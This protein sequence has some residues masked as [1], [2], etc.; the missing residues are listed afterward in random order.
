MGGDLANISVRGTSERLRFKMSNTGKIEMLGNYVVDNGT[1][2]SKAVLERT[3]QISKG[4]N[5]QWDGNPMTPDLN[6]NATYLRTISNA[7]Q[8]LQM[9]NL[10]PI[11]VQLITKISGKLNDPQIE[12][13]IDAPD[14]SSQLKEALATK[15]SNKDERIMQFGSILVLNS[16]NTSNI[17]G[18]ADMKVGAVAGSTGYNILF[19][20]LG[21]VLSAIS[22]EVQ[23]DLDYISGDAASNTGDRA[24][25]NLKFALSPRWTF[26]TG[27]GI[28]ITR[29][30]NANAQYLSGQG[31][32]EYDWS[33]NNDGS[34]LLRMYSKP[35]NIGLLPGVGNTSANQA[36]GAGV[37]YSKSFNSLF[38]SNKKAKNKKSNAMNNKIDSTKNTILK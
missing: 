25:A 7:G 27:L 32:I 18:V 4:S 13:N 2:L 35:S 23:V 38:K 31:I 33:K 21:S 9:N 34:R 20:Q 15:L 36:Y 30:D 10:P 37:V 1:F 14:A 17:G 22:N 26:K 6:I 11:N 16:F 19:K 12:F 3:F 5:I 24:N 29:A 28:P 8:Y